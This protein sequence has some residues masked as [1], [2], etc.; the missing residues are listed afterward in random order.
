MPRSRPVLAAVGLTLV[1]LVALLGLVMERAPVS[2]ADGPEPAWLA[3]AAKILVVAV[4]LGVIALRAKLDAAV[5]PWW[6]PA[7]LV[8]LSGLMTLCHYLMVDQH[9]EPAQWQR[10]IYL[11]ILNQRADP[12]HQFRA[13]PYGFTRV[14]ELLTGDWWF[15]CIAYRWFF[16]YWFVWSW[17]RF[18][19]LFL[20]PRPALATLGVLL[21]YYPLS[22]QYYWGQLTDPLSHA[23]FV[24]ALIYLVQDRVWLLAA[25]L[26]LGICAKETVVLLVPV[27]VACYWRG[28]LR[29][30]LRAA[31]LGA[32]CVAA[33]LGAR[34]PF[35]WQSGAGAMNGVERL[36]VGTNLGLDRLGWTE[37]AARTFV[38]LAMN[39]LH[40]LAFVVPFVPFIVRNWRHTD[41][42]L[43]AIFLTLTPLVLLSSLC[44]SWLY[45][46]RN[47]VP[48]LPVLTTMAFARQRSAPP[49]EPP[50]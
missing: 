44:Y 34:L 47:Y 2:W 12:P 43:K 19:R 33:F 13:L 42:R 48:L 35:G 36:M 50:T 32:V 6:V 15:A 21:V 24:L 5:E 41:G 18:A 27:Y 16:S 46:S 10:D 26:A 25:A 39:Y 4:F 1:A 45:E 7:G 28:G 11:H 23:L 37:T 22:V 38:P 14:L 9:A 49:G 3:W 31:A 8:G 29:T 20:P 17:L 30:W 40:P